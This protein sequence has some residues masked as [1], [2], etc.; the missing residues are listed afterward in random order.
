MKMKNTITLIFKKRSADD[1]K[2]QKKRGEN[3]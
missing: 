3:K 1:T 2:E